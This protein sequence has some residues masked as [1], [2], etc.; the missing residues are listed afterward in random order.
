MQFICPALATVLRNTYQ[1]PVRL[2]VHGGEEIPSCEGTTKG[3]PLDMAMYALA[4]T[5]LINE[6]CNQ[7]PEAS[8]VWFADDSTAVSKCTALR[9]RWDL[10]CT[11]GPKYGY[12]PNASKSFLIVKELF[13]NEARRGFKDTNVIITSEG[14]RHLGAALGSS[15]SS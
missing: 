10:L 3:G 4:I 5:P 7:C 1:A 14:A 11:S 12:H 9:K 8:Q 13:V 2:F 6:L 15:G